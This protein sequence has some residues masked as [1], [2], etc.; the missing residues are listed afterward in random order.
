MRSHKLGVLLEFLD[1]DARRNSVVRLYVEDVLDCSSFGAF[2]P[3]RNLVDGQPEAPTLG[4]E[5]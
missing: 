2:C 3:F 4:R 5:E 1:A